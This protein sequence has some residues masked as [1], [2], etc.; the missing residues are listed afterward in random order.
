MIVG[1]NHDRTFLLFKR[2]KLIS[3][4]KPSPERESTDPD[5][6]LLSPTSP[7]PQVGSIFFEDIGEWRNYNFPCHV[8]VQLHYCKCEMQVE[9]SVPHFAALAIKSGKLACHLVQK[10]VAAYLISSSNIASFYDWIRMRPMLQSTHGVS[11]WG[12]LGRSML[13]GSRLHLSVRRWLPHLVRIA[14]SWIGS[15]FSRVPIKFNNSFL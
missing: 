12:I 7:G 9:P 11:G 4:C 10:E 13:R 15:I 3:I 1:S 6:L 5:T 2:R 8:L 14:R